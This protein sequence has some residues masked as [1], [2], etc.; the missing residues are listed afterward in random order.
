[1]AIRSFLR[2]LNFST[3]ASEFIRPILVGLLIATIFLGGVQLRRWIGDATRHVRYQHDI[4]NGFYWGSEV[5]TQA[6]RLSPDEASANSWPGFF[7]GYLALYD[8]V[9]HTAYKND[10]ALD[11]PPLRLLGMAIW[12]KQVRNTFPE[13]DDGHPKL[14]NPLLKINLVCE[15]LS[16]IAIFLLVRLCVR[17]S[18]SATESSLLHSFP[19]EQRAWLCGLAAASAAWLE[20]SMILDAHG[21]PQ[22][23]VWILPFYL[24]A[25]LA[26]LKNRWFCCGCLLAAGAML[27]GQLLFVAPFFVLWPLWQKRWIPALHM[28]A[29]FV[30]TTA[31]IVSPWLSRTPVAW[32]A[33]VAVAGITL[34]FLLRYKVSHPIAWLAGIVGSAVFVIGVFTGGS[35]AW[36]KIGFIYGSEH[37][38]YLFISS[39][40]NLP[41]LLSK[42]GW[43]LK[44]SF[45]SVD[46]GSLHLHITLQWTLRLLYLGALALCARGM[47]RHLRDRDPRALIALAAPWLLMFALLGQMHERYLMWGAVVSAVALGVSVR[48]TIIHFVISIAS[49]AMIVHVMLIDKK[50]EATLPAIDALKQIRSLGSI[51]VLACV[52]IYLWDTISTRIPHFRHREIRS[53][54]TPSLSLAPEPE[55]A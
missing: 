15:L 11:Y 14:V 21:W 8:R 38:P 25:A 32:M 29:G 33:V 37:Y 22:W 4:V 40:Y 45:L 18:S 46:F 2:F 27:K 3:R 26:A 41:S 9:K 19:Q 30:A 10:Y 31:F 43:S 51:V 5:L 42:V 12:A 52:A 47:A 23:D 28:L 54:V 35:F 34:A 49:T 53:R 48:L 50:L 44:D 36:L 13:V 16:A 1:M 24:F 39:C 7:R 6:R 55:E 20:P 17:R